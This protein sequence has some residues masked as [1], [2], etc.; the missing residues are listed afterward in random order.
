MQKIEDEELRRVAI[1][2]LRLAARQ[3]GELVACV[4]TQHLRATLTSIHTMLA[5]AADE[6]QLN[7]PGTDCIADVVHDETVQRHERAAKTRARN[8]SVPRD[9]LR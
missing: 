3:L 4:K 6:L 8:D 5:T 1:F 7:R 2:K 9:P